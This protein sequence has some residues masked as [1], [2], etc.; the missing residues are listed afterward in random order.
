MV[1]FAGG[2]SVC[3]VT[4][5]AAVCATVVSITLGIRSIIV[6]AAVGP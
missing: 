5:T 4:L 6:A 1:T 3:F 2:S